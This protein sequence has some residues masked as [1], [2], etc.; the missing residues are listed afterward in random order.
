MD[1]GHPR[2]DTARLVQLSRAVANFLDTFDTSDSI[3]EVM[4]TI[5]HLRQEYREVGKQD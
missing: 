3:V 1:V 2:N 4:K 5:E